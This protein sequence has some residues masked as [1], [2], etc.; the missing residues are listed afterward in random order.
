MPKYH[1]YW[2]MA[3]LHI[4]YPFVINFHL[5]NLNHITLL[6]EVLNVNVNEKKVKCTYHIMYSV[7][8][9]N[10]FIKSKQQLKH[11]LRN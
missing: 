10:K 8:Y 7:P 2:Y 11:I 5:F 6:L 9:N 3:V 4:F 1:T